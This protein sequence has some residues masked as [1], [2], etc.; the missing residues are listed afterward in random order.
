[1]AVFQELDKSVETGSLSDES[2]GATFGEVIR[3][4]EPL[5]ETKWRFGKPNYATVNKFYFEN[6]VMKHPEGSLESVVTKIVKNWEVESHHIADPNQWKTM[7]TPSFKIAVN[8]G[9]TANAQLMA[10]EGPY[11]LLMGESP[12]YSSKQNTFETSNQLWS[13]TFPEGFAWECIEVLSGPPTVTFRWR[14]F[15]VFSGEFVDK[16]GCIHKG[17]GQLV[18]VLGLCIAKVTDELKVTSLDVYYNPEDLIRPLLL[19]S[20]AEGRSVGPEGE[21][22]KP[23]GAQGCGCS[24]KG[25]ACSVM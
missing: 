20:M 22:L 2:K 25:D 17:N 9:K 7:D 1:M 5:P 10:E 12:M 3:D 18:S 19:N 21:E 24:D 14:H 11:N 6:R 4:Y 23:G 16:S 13:R 15:G 8:G